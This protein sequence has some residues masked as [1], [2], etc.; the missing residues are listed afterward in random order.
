MISTPTPLL[1]PPPPTHTHTC[2]I[3]GNEH[4]YRTHVFP[5]STR[6]IQLVYT[7]TQV[8]GDCDHLKLHDVVEVLGVMAV[9]P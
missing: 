2:R 5:M 6:C 9:V 8:Y 3:Y 1:S 4:T 7:H